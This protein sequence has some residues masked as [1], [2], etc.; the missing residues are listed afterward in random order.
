MAD[1]RIQY[2]EEMVGAGHPTKSDTLNRRGDVEHATDGTHKIPKVADTVLSGAP[3]V[4]TIKGSDG[5]N[6]YVKGY[7]TKA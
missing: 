2:S 7:P 3:A 5:T 1:Q 6:Y 4:L